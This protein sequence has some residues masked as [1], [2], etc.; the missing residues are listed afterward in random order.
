MANKEL[1][2]E[3]QKIQNEIERDKQRAE[4]RRKAAL[5][6][7]AKISKETSALPKD[8][9]A[10]NSTLIPKKIRYLPQ[11]MIIKL[12]LDTPRIKLVA[13]DN[14]EH[15]GNATYAI[16]AIMPI[17]SSKKEIEALQKTIKDNFK[18]NVKDVIL[19][20]NRFYDETKKKLPI[21]NIEDMIQRAEPPINFSFRSRTPESSEFLNWC[22]QA[23]RV[24]LNLL[25]LSHLGLLTESDYMSHVSKMYDGLHRYAAFV[26]QARRTAFSGVKRIVEKDQKSKQELEAV[27]SEVRAANIDLNDNGEIKELSKAELKASVEK[28]ANTENV[29]ADAS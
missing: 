16:T 29:V 20:S 11:D 14:Y 7:E 13:F 22:Y 5:E 27:K 12:P 4:Q 1:L 21:A 25:K 2:S 19:A 28:E 24:C 6:R 23:D 18:K 8:Y 17:S 10:R 26:Y 9:N 15:I 3:K